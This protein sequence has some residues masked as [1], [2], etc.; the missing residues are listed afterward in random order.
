MY[1][2]LRL[3]GRSLLLCGSA[4]QVG[5]RV[6]HGRELQWF[7]ALGVIDV[8]VLGRDVDLPPD[9]RDHLGETLA[10]VEGPKR[11]ASWVTALPTAFPKSGYQ[12]CRTSDNGWMWRRS[13]RCNRPLTVHH[14]AAGLRRC[15]MTSKQKKCANLPLECRIWL[16]LVWVL[17][18]TAV[19]EIR[20]QS[21]RLNANVE[22][23]DPVVPRGVGPRLRAERLDRARG[24]GHPDARDAL[25]GLRC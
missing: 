23:G 25:S 2:A 16:Q 24:E 12:R 17:S 3:A 1:L 21:G 11:K 4:Y 10:G 9:K 20:V 7:A 15:S 22:S 6:A 8:Y 19:D 14:N 13:G 18:S 5:G